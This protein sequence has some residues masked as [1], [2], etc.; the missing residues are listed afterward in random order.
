M[1]S[2]F[3]N[4]T[5]DNVASSPRLD[6]ITNEKQLV[7]RYEALILVLRPCNIPAITSNFSGHNLQ[8]LIGKPTP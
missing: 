1:T 3:H 7:A 4:L 6:Q 2:S 8:H 5:D